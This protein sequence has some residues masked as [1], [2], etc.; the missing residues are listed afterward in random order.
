[1]IRYIVENLRSFVKDSLIIL[2]V[3]LVSYAIDQLAGRS[4]AIGFVGSCIILCGLTIKD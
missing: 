4:L 1:M 3:V 2:G